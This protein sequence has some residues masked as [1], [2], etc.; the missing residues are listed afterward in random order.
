[1]LVAMLNGRTE[2]LEYLSSSSSAINGIAY[3]DPRINIAVANRMA[4]VVECFV[5]RKPRFPW[6]GHTG[7]GTRACAGLAQA[8]PG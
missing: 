8:V 1:M 5:R 4:P 2:V 7:N 3:C 6:S